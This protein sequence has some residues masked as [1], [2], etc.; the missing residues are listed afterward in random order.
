MVGAGLR[1]VFMNGPQSAYAVGYSQYLFAYDPA[2]QRFVAGDII[3][4]HDATQHASALERHLGSLQP[5]HVPGWPHG[6][7]MQRIRNDWYALMLN[8]SQH[9][10]G[11]SGLPPRSDA[12]V[13]VAA[14]PLRK[15]Q[16]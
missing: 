6:E 15:M 13:P 10:T 4:G 1:A 16:R 14:L 9:F 3:E 12:D 8:P 11:I 2:M 5:G 7:H